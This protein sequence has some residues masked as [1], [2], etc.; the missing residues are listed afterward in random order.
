MAFL[1][2]Q[3]GD[4]MGDDE[5]DEGRPDKPHRVPAGRYAS[6]VAVVAALIDDAGVE[7]A[8]DE[9]DLFVLDDGGW[10]YG[11]MLSAMT[12]L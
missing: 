9:G 5:S 1:T 4:R 11:E 3:R 8:T 12:A 10:R 2:Q 7:E 6:D